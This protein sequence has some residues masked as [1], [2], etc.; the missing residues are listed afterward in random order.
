MRYWDED[1]PD[2]DAEDREFATAW[3]KQPKWVVS[4]SLN[5]VGP[6]ASLIADDFENRIRKLKAE[7]TGEIQVGGPMLAK[8]LTDANLIDEYRLY[9]RPVVLGGGQPFFAGPCPP[10][11]LISN[12]LIADDLIRLTYVPA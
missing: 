10:L 4:H 1:L 11:H 5:S 6:N 2:W 9:L 12:D 8:A 7:L 3:R